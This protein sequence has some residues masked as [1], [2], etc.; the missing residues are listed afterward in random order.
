[1]SAF[2]H[3]M[4]GTSVDDSALVHQ[5]G[6]G[7]LT[8]DMVGYSFTEHIQLGTLQCAVDI[9][10]CRDVERASV[11]PGLVL[12]KDLYGALNAGDRIVWIKHGNSCYER[13]AYSKALGGGAY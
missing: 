1:M 11:K 10:T 13:P 12:T 5:E 6:Y 8:E 7:I 3:S 2:V 9:E 4:N